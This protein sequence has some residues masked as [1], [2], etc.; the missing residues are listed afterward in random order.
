LRTAPVFELFDAQGHR[1]HSRQ[2]QGKPMIV[3]FWASWCA[4]CLEEFPR[5]LHLQGAVS[6]ALEHTPSKFSDALKKQ[7]RELQWVAIS[8]DSSWTDVQRVWPDL[9]KY[10]QGRGSAALR[11]VLDPEALVSEAYGTFQFPETYLIGSQQEILYKW[12]G[13]QNWEDPK[14]IEEIVSKL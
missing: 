14:I 6:A 3:H 13:P 10:Q 12:V 7:L 1:V 2:F 5:W 11:L 8:Q 4:P 9:S